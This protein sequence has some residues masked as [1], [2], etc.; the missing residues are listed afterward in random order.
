MFPE[1]FSD[2]PNSTLFQIEIKNMLKN[3]RMFPKTEILHGIHVRKQTLC[4][5]LCF[6]L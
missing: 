3:V 6:L 4:C 1:K 5:F 2:S